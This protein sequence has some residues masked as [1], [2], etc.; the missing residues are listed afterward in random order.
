MHPQKITV[1]CAI[2]A[3]N[4]IGPYFFEDESGQTTTVTVDYY[5]QMIRHFLMP[6]MEEQN[7]DY[8]WF[9]QDG[10]T[11]HTAKETTRILKDLFPGRLISRFGDLHWLARSPNLTSPDIF[12]W[13]YL[14]EKVHVNKPQT[15]DQLKN[16]ILQEIENI[17]IEILKKV[18][19]N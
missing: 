2:H 8:M 13:G 9:Q 3:K 4:V 5:R 16:N 7:L 14:K 6:Q 1:R 19:K 18:M 11:P 15:L 17:P 10:A 12:L